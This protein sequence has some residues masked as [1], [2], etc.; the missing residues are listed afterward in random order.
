MHLNTDKIIKEKNLTGH[1]R[2][3]CCSVLILALV[4]AVLYGVLEIAES[5]LCKWHY[6]RR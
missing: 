5:I 3:L 2:F 6:V 1:I 4:S